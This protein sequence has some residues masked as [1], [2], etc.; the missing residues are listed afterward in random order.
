M[1]QIRRPDDLAFVR[2][3]SGSGEDDGDE[4]A[5]LRVEGDEL[6]LGLPFAAGAA[7]LP[8]GDAV[9]RRS[10]IVHGG[11]F[12]LFEVELPSHL[13]QCFIRSRERR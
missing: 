12:I 9:A 6:D 8:E 2:R 5:V 3:R 4:S 11:E 7:F 10:G 1:G 13:G